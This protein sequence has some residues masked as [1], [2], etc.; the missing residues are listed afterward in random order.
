MY[1]DD[2]NGNFAYFNAAQ[3]F[4]KVY[5]YSFVGGIDYAYNYDNQVNVVFGFH[6]L[7][8]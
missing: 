8:P 5:A 6:M 3:G 4:G 7:T 1:S 2:A